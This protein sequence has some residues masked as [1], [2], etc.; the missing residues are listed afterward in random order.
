MYIMLVE[1][2]HLQSAALQEDL[3][4]EFPSARIELVRTEYEFYR[5]LDAIERDR[6]DVIVMDVMLRWTNP[7]P[8]MP[9]P[10]DVVR[11]EGF[12]K[13]G[14]RCTALLNENEKTK[15]IPVILYTSLEKQDLH[16]DLDKLPQNVE[17]TGKDADVATLAMRI[18]ELRKKSLGIGK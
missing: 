13:A 17:Y 4:R 2:D 11:A 3:R 6:P 14:L 9:P 8:E 16:D 7:A 18:R 5:K 10:S 15:N 1:D 12:Y